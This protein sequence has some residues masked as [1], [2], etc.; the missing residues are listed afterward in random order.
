MDLGLGHTSVLQ[1]LDE[2]FHGLLLRALCCIQVKTLALGSDN[3]PL[4]GT[5][6]QCA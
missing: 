6:R 5:L 4:S 2:K 1:D 3:A